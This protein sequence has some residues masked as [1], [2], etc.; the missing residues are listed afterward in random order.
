[1]WLLEVSILLKSDHKESNGVGVDVGGCD[2]VMQY[3]KKGSNVL[4]WS[5]FAL[6]PENVP[7]TI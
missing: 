3:G 5:W 6:W 7:P 2:G 4:T 1:M